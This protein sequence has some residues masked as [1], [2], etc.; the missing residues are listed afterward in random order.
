MSGE[1]GRG[2]QNKNMVFAANTRD[3]GMRQS[4]DSRFENDS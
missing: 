3:I 2:R 1:L 4:Y